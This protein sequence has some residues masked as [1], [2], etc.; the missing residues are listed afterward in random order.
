MVVVLITYGCG[1]FDIWIVTVRLHFDGGNN[2][3]S[4]PTPKDFLLRRLLFF[5]SPKNW[6]PVTREKVG[7]PHLSV[8]WAV[9]KIIILSSCS[10]KVL[11]QRV[12]DVLLRPFKILFAQESGVNGG[13]VGGWVMWTLW[14][15]FF[16]IL[17][18]HCPLDSSP[19]IPQSQ[20]SREKMLWKCERKKNQIPQNSL[21]LGHLSLGI[22]MTWCDWFCSNG[23]TWLVISD[24]S[25]NPLLWP[26]YC[27]PQWALGPPWKCEVSPARLTKSDQEWP[28]MRMRD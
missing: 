7:I 3:S 19:P 8:E 28:K 26:F 22:V 25:D 13:G 17:F 24:I 9:K 6:D 20:V 12:R 5:T 15:Y 10:H 18:S 2:I 14:R 16:Y 1:Y 27:G 4:S 21:L 11:H 23:F